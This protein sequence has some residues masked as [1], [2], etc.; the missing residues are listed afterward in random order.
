MKAAREAATVGGAESPDSRGTSRAG[1]SIGDGG[2][3]GNGRPGR[4]GAGGAG[5][6]ARRA[7]TEARPS[8]SRPPQRAR[9]VRSR[10]AS[11]ALVGWARMSA[12]RST[13]QPR[14]ASAS[15]LPSASIRAASPPAAS[16]RGRRRGT[17]SCPRNGA[18]QFG[19]APARESAEAGGE[20]EAER[21][22][23]HGVR[24][25]ALAHRAQ[26]AHHVG[27]EARLDRAGGGGDAP[28]FGRWG[29]SSRHRH[30]RA[31][32]ALPAVTSHHGRVTIEHRFFSSQGAR[33]RLGGAAGDYAISRG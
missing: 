26:A 23:R 1:G 32:V 7:A 31:G 30:L 13:P 15:A 27:T 2:G 14:S 16:R 17:P 33:G 9:I 5:G 22:G 28:R 6:G 12:S 10:R 3:T 11:A 29:R 4:G 18:D 20:V 21:A 25:V 19:D 8:A 24:R